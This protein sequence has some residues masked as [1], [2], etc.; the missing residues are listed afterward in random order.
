MSKLFEQYNN[1]PQE[2]KDRIGKVSARIKNPGVHAV[3]IIEAVEI[4][5]NRI[6]VDFKTDAG[7]TADWTGF[8]ESKDEDGNIIPNTRTMT[9]FTFI[10][11]AAGLNF[12]NVISQT[13]DTTKTFK[14]GDVPAVIFT[15]LAKKK[16]F[17]TTSTVLEGD[18]KDPKRCYVKQEVNPFK[19]FDIKK[20]STLEID[21]KAPAGTTME[22]ADIDAKSEISISYKWQGN[23]ACEKKYL[24]LSERNSVSNPSSATGVI[25]DNAAANEDPDDV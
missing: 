8:L 17:I 5:G 13:M 4:D 10:C 2:D 23:A 9:Q 15:A 21:A 11:K 6:K 3:T 22:A 1:L 19:F 12:Q 16:L 20:R 18:D 7:E 14:K 25:A 24:E